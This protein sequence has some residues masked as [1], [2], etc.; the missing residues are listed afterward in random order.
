[1]ARALGHELVIVDPRSA[2]ATEERFGDVTILHEWPEEALTRIG[3][4][5]ATAV[6]VLSHDAK[7]DDA[8]LIAA[9]RSDAFYV[10]ALGSR[11]THAKRVE[12]L[13]QAG[14]AAADI[15]RIHAPIGLD[16]GAQGSAEIALSIMAEITAVQRGKDGARQ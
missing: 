9:L 4:D 16:I 12:R 13:L 10:G 3:L 1:M 14:I 2:F 8:A 5:A 6:T 7:I 15:E 11:K